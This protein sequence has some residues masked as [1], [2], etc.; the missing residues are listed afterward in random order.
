MSL[1]FY[2][3]SL[4]LTPLARALH[5]D[6]PGLA[7]LCLGATCVDNHVLLMPFVKC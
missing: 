5:L 3:L 1:C 4:G 6:A 2:A 7:P